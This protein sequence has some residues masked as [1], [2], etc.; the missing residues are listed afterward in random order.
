MGGISTYS[1]LGLPKELTITVF[2]ISLIAALAPIASG[3]DL[4]LLKIP[5]F[6]PP[7]QSRLR[8]WGPITLLFALLLFFPLWPA[9]QSLKPQETRWGP[10]DGKEPGIYISSPEVTITVPWASLKSEIE[11]RLLP[12]VVQVPAGSAV[13][14][15]DFRG[16][17]NWIVAVI[18]PSK[19][20]VANVWFGPDPMSNWAFDGLVRVGRPDA[21]DPEGKAVVWQTFQRF[22]DGSYRRKR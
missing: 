7:L 4:G 19:E 17:R 6:A 15:R 5:R 16:K 8:I 11:T 22:S 20:R 21:D 2:T 18:S 12:Q 13:E 14:L 10:V 1:L 3:A 9:S